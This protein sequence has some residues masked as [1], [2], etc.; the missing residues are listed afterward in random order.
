MPEG[1][2]EEKQKKS[3]RQ[4]ELNDRKTK[5][6]NKK[7]QIESAK[8]LVDEMKE[9][10]KA[11]IAG[12]GL[13]AAERT[14]RLNNINEF[15]NKSKD[16]F[17]FAGAEYVKGRVGGMISKELNPSDKALLSQDVADYVRNLESV[18][19]ALVG[20]SK[21]FGSFK[22]ALK[23]LNRLK[24]NLDV[25]NPEKVNEYKEKVK[26]AAEKATVYLRYKTYQY[27]DKRKGD[28]KRSELEVKRVGTV[29]AILNGLKKL[30]V[31]NS[32]ELIIPEKNDYHVI[33]P[34]KIPGFLGEY[35]DTP[36]K[37]AFDKVIERYT[38]RGIING[39][40]PKMRKSFV[41]ALACYVMKNKK[42]AVYNKEDIV[43]EYEKL[44]KEFN[45][46][47]MTAEELRDAL[48]NPAMLGKT[49]S[50]KIVNTYA[51]DSVADYEKLVG[52]MK[53]LYTRIGTKNLIVKNEDFKI[54]LGHI[55]QL[56]HLPET[57]EGM[58]KEKVFQYVGWVNHE[59]FRTVRDRMLRDPKHI[60]QAD[61]YGIIIIKAIGDSCTGM[62]N[63]TKNL[64]SELIEKRA[65]KKDRQGRYLINDPR[66]FNF[67]N[68]GS[69][70]FERFIN[71]D[72][73]R[74]LKPDLLE[75]Q[76]QQFAMSPKRI[77]EEMS[78]DKAEAIKGDNTKSKD[79]PVKGNKNNKTKSRPRSNSM[80]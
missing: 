38:G 33:V 32:N 11:T 77:R 28:H 68:Y 80:G 20:S 67:D 75:K 79:A 13:A 66:F 34:T 37:D 43:K 74:Q 59:I 5:L 48:Q 9:L 45:F 1:T 52:N 40:L 19:P 12:K 53:A 73:R 26:E 71:K 17:V 56:A 31:P 60:D 47:D 61:K 70:A 69:N 55:E 15:L 58:D 62:M 25:N 8:G 6:E 72:Q 50:E 36:K 18:D 64:E 23:E 42:N 57:L 44:N 27:N 4:N 65:P 41:K 78:A 21:Q 16:N 3:T 35:A 46:D 51:P 39:T 10:W 14:T 76:S 24:R 22:T 7:P 2:E 29:D 30:T 63:L 49:L 54:V